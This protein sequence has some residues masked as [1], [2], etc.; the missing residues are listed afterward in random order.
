[1]K[2]GKRILPSALEALG[3]I[4]G[5]SRSC[6]STSLYLEKYRLLLDAGPLS[7]YN[8]HSAHATKVLITHFHH[9]HWTGI[10]SL[11]GLKKCRDVYDPVHIFSPKGTISFLRSVLLELKN[12]REL[13]I[14]LESEL[15]SSSISE[16]TI[17]VILHPLEANQTVE[18]GDELRIETFGVVHRSESLGFK[19]SAKKK[20]DASWTRL[21]TYTG[22]T[23]TAPLQDGDILSSPVLITECTYLEPD[24]KEKAE[25]RGHMTLSNIVDVES[26]FKGDCILLI[27]FKVSYTE[28][29]ISRSIN[30]YKYSRVKPTA[31][32][33]KITD[34]EMS[35][36]I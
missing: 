35:R 12:K 15:E 21:L 16:N 24:K 2:T 34:M 9:D 4:T 20:D 36:S 18:T 10:I 17:P 28:K 7:C 13:S 11:L 25:E 26:K 8:S 32:C 14:N 6:L 5:Y 30:S 31:I 33:T 27:H 29:E 22:D 19:F 1:M 23:S 3:P